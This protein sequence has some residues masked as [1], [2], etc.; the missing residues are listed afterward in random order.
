MKFAREVQD[1]M[2]AYPGREFRM[3]HIVRYVANGRTLDRKQRH[4][5]KVGVWR[6]LLA[7]AESGAITVRPPTAKIGGPAF[8]AWKKCHTD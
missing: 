4:S 5:M 3:M 8:Y 7:L 1:L 6:V 2:A